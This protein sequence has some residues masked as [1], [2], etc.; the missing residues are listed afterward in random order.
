LVVVRELDDDQTEI[1]ERFYDLD[2]LFQVDGLVDVA[3]GVK[4]IRFQNIF[5]GP[6]SRQDYDGN[7]LEIG[8]ILD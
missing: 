8:V 6:G 7:A 2:E 5:L 4:V 3:I 1:L